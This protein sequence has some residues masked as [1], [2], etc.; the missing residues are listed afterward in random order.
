[1][2]GAYRCDTIP[3]EAI[4]GFVEMI[5]KLLPTCLAKAAS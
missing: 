2:V 1:M 3:A 4:L 5:V